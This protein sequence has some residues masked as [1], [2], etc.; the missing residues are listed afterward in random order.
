[1][2]KI[3]NMAKVHIIRILCTLATLVGQS[4]QLTFKII[5][6]YILPGLSNFSHCVMAYKLKIKYWLT[7]FDAILNLLLSDIINIYLTW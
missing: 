1:M 4:K 3:W 5:L 7:T 2:A 6:L